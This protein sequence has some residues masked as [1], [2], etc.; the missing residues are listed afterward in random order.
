MSNENKEAAAAHEGAEQQ[1][2][3]QPDAAES[4]TTKAK[5]ES[6]PKAKAKTETDNGASALEAV[7]QAACKRHK[8]AQAWVT[9]DGQVFPQE[10]D[11]K[12]HARNLGDKV[13]LKV[14]AK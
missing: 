2:G 1:P 4:K 5:S 12:E 11:A 8:L 13:I 14:T 6:K 7:G 3:Q 9:S 10:G